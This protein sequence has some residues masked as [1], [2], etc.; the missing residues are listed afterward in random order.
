MN[1]RLIRNEFI[2]NIILFIQ[3]IKVLHSSRNLSIFRKSLNR[4]TTKKIQ[5]KGLNNEND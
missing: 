5:M 2:S 4:P 3:F 1:T